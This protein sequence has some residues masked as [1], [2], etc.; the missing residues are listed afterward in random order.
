ME[1]VTSEAGATVEAGHVNVHLNV[2]LGHLLGGAE[3]EG[4]VEVEED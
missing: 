3:L 2:D 1:S 4:E